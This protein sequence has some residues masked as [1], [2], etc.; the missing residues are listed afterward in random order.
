MNKR[1]AGIIPL[2]MIFFIF[3]PCGCTA[4]GSTTSDKADNSY[5]GAMVWD[6]E[7][8]HPDNYDIQDSEIRPE[9]EILANLES[10]DPGE[11]F[12]GIWWTY[13][14]PDDAELVSKAGKAV[15]TVSGDR[16]DYAIRLIFGMGENGKNAIA[17][18]LDE[19]NL[20]KIA[21][22]NCT[23][24][25]PPTD[26]LASRILDL[27]DVDDD[28]I[29][30]AVMQFA[31]AWEIKDVDLYQNTLR[32]L[33]LEPVDDEFA[34]RAYYTSYRVSSLMHYN[35]PRI[36]QAY[37]V[38]ISNCGKLPED[39]NN[40]EYLQALLSLSPLP[41]NIVEMLVSRFDD[42]SNLDKLSA[43]GAIYNSDSSRTPYLQFLLEK[44]ES[45]N[46][47]VSEMA[48]VALASIDEL[49]DEV[50]ENFPDRLVEALDEKM[51][52]S[53]QPDYALEDLKSFRARLGDFGK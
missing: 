49:P 53:E 12:E 4:P 41:E 7:Y 45:K 24:F 46:E 39:F 37:S 35:D 43:A 34:L 13:F 8:L 29:R 40:G 48:A 36:F 50:Y 9:E 38:N 26:R 28:E 31:L 44:L 25:G 10:P 32:L 42:Y 14:Y 18:L 11:I 3:V 16:Q 51:D 15:K 20:R 17:N 19:E 1:F 2:V 6:G 22:T 33:E 23:S 21:L 47:I 27:V 30:I 52:W 5:S